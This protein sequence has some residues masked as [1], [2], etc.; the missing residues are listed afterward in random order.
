MLNFIISVIKRITKNRFFYNFV[1]P[2]RIKKRTVLKQKIKQT[3]KLMESD[4]KK[5]YPLKIKNEKTT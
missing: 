1:Q 3:E 5:V 4:T 2:E